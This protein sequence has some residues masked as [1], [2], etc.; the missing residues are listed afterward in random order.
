[1][2]LIRLA[3][4]S[5]L[6]LGLTACGGGGIGNILGPI[7]GAAA[8]CDPGTQV[9]IASPT[10]GQT[11]VSGNIGQIVIVANGDT[12]TL[13]NTSN[14]WYVTLTPQYGGSSIQGGNLTPFDGRNLNHPYTSDYYYASSIGQLP[15]GTTWTAYLNE[16]NANCAPV[17]LNS[18]ST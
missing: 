13:Y 4:A 12:N 15:S 6:V 3:L 10:P 16:Q 18:F 5:S 1:M 8:Q 2:S 7:G 17:P 14:Q 9:Q 11:G